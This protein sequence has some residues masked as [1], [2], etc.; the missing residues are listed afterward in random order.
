MRHR[1][2]EG[3]TVLVEAWIFALA[4]VLSLAAMACFLATGRLNRTEVRR[5]TY[6]APNGRLD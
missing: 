6:R 2:R 1:E 3:Y 5:A 4:G